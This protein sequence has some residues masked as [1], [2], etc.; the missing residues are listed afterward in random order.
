MKKL[1]STILCVSLMSINSMCLASDTAK[2]KL[3]LTNVPLQSA[4]QNKYSAYRIEYFNEGQNPVR[5][6]DVKCYNKIAIVDMSDATV[7][8][9]K[10]DIMMFALSPLTLGITGMVAGTKATKQSFQLCPAMDE[11]K[12]FNAMDY[13]NLGADG[14]RLQTQNE[15]LSQGQSI[16]FNVLVPINDKPQVVGAFEDTV[17]HQYIRVEGLK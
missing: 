11:A 10:H 6:N 3:N 12:R 17:T 15:I 13:T 2:V 8:L 14:S 16:Q 7:K 9:K 4:L 5:V 1:F